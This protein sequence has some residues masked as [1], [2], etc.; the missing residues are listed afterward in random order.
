MNRKLLVYSPRY[1]NQAEGFEAHEII[2]VV[3]E[4]TTDNINPFADKIRITMTELATEGELDVTV[5]APPPFKVVVH[6]LSI[7]L[8]REIQGLNS[9]NYLGSKQSKGDSNGES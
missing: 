6:N 3:D 2:E 8:P 4:V 9:I 7:R 1:G 5:L